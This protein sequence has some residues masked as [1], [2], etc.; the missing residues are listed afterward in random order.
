MTH[1]FPTRLFSDPLTDAAVVGGSAAAAPDDAREFVAE[2]GQLSNLRLDLPQMRGR[3]AVGLAAVARRIVRQVEQRADFLDRETQLARM[4]HE[5]EPRPVR[6][7]I[8][9][10]V[11]G[12]KIG[13]AS[14]RERVCQ[15]VS[16]TGGAG[17]LK[18][19]RTKK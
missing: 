19:K 8:A 17:A 12:G 5:A 15:Y 2:R 1:S 4:A 3:D 9:A 7:R 11:G 6:A 13:R 16:Y 14:C 18:K 10:I